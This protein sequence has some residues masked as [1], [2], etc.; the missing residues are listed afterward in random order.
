[1]Q[2]LSETG[3]IGTFFYVIS[4]IYVLKHLLLNISYNLK[5]VRNNLNK[6]RMFNLLALFIALMP[7][8]PS[9]N[10]FNNWIS[11]VSFF[12]VGFYLLSIS[13]YNEY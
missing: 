10:F 13:K 8:V 1:M 9:G 2:F 5:D 7:I 11:I 3:L 6:S 12:P 4:L